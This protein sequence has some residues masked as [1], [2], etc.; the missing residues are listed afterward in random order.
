[1][2]HKF[3]CT[4]SSLAMVTAWYFQLAELIRYGT[5]F[6][7][8]ATTHF[9]EWIRHLE[10]LNAYCSWI[11]SDKRSVKTLGFRWSDV[12]VPLPRARTQYFETACFVID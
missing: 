12:S 3:C 9:D 8:I 7:F 11:C 5:F 6:I 2:S 4:S 1:V 10:I